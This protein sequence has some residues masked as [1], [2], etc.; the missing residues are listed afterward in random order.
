MGKKSRRI[1]ICAFVKFSIYDKIMEIIDDDFRG[2][3]MSGIGLALFLYGISTTGL[4]KKQNGI[5]IPG[6]IDVVPVVI[7]AISLFLIYIMK[8]YNKIS[9]DS[10]PFPDTLTDSADNKSAILPVHV[11]RRYRKMRPS[12]R[13]FEP[14]KLSEW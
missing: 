9:D 4:I 3:V 5:Y 11:H 10:D 14:D 13:V 7:T 1:L 12:P 8:K 2:M 6:S